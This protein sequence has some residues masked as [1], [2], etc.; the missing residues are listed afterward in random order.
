M[1][2]YYNCVCFFFSIDKM[3]DKNA[4]ITLTIQMKSLNNINLFSPHSAFLTFNCPFD[5][6]KIII[7]FRVTGSALYITES[8]VRR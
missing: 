8:S 6:D 5:L 3:I 4:L 7:C 1:L 2:V